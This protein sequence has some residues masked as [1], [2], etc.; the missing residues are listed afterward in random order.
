MKAKA[1]KKPK[2]DAEIAKKRARSPTRVDGLLPKQ[3]AFV[4]EFLI[5]GNATQAAIR[6][7]YSPKSAHVVAHDLLKNPKVAAAIAKKRE[8]LDARMKVRLDAMEL[9]EERVAK[10]IARLAFFDPRKMFA[11]DGRPLNITELDDD[12]AA[13]IAGLEV[14]EQYEGVGEDRELV[15]LVKKYKVSDKNAALEKAAKILG[16]FKK[17]NEQPGAATAN[18]ITALLASMGR[19][20]FPVAK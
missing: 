4:D 18:A 16:M 6:A 14:L 20:A 15:G 8:E 17:D 9:T 13:C 19:S 12:T 1:T 5:D 7:G 2:Q 10:E 3:A 11:A